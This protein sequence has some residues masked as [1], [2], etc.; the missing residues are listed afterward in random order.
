MSGVSK[1]YQLTPAIRTG[2]PAASRIWL[3][4]VCQNPA[5]AAGAACAV[6]PLGPARTV[7]ATTAATTPT[8]AAAAATF[9]EVTLPPTCRITPASTVGRRVRRTQHRWD[10]WGKG[11]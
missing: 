7:P 5:P 10:R 9:V 4:L 2:F 6:A 1:P 3:P 11:A 8:H